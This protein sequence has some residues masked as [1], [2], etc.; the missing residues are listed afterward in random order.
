MFDSSKWLLFSTFLFV[1]FVSKTYVETNS[2]IPDLRI[3]KTGSDWPGFL[4][5]AGDGKSPENFFIDPWGISGPSL[6]WQTK[7]GESYGA[8]AI[9]RGRLFVFD[10]YQNLARLS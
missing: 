10:R 7:I 6:V 1:L 2:Q 8:P 5:P 9:S 3:R 4:G